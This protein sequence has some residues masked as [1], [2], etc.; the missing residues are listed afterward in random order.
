VKPNVDYGKAFALFIESGADSLREYMNSLNGDATEKLTMRD[1][2]AWPDD[3]LHSYLSKKSSSSD[4]SDIA[5]LRGNQFQGRL[6]YNQD[7]SFR[8]TDQIRELVETELDSKFPALD[9]IRAKKRA[10]LIDKLMTLSAPKESGK[11]SAIMGSKSQVI[12]A[13]SKDADLEKIVGLFIE[14]R[15]RR[16]LTPK[17]LFEDYYNTIHEDK[18]PNYRKW[19]TYAQRNYRLTF[20]SA[21]LKEA[22][23]LLRNEIPPEFKRPTQPLLE[24]LIQLHDTKSSKQG[25]YQIS[26]LSA[27]DIIGR[28]DM[29]KA[30]KRNDIYKYWKGKHSEFAEFT[31]AHNA[32]VAAIVD[33]DLS[34]HEELKRKIDEFSE[35][36]VDELNYIKLYNPV[37]IKDIDKIE[38]KALILLEEFLKNQSELPEE[39]IMYT[40]KVPGVK[41]SSDVTDYT[42]S[43]ADTEPVKDDLEE[44]ILDTLTDITVRKVDPLYAYILEETDAL[45]AGAVIEDQLDDI[46]D[47]LKTGLIIVEV[48]DLLPALEKFLAHLK[49]SKAGKL[50]EYYLPAMT[51]MM[52]RKDPN[53]AIAEYLK[54]FAQ[55][56]EYGEKNELQS[57]GGTTGLKPKGGRKRTVIGRSGVNA[58]THMNDFKDLGITEKF[59]LLLESI[60]KFF[61]E[62]SRNQNRPFDDELPFIEQTGSR[63]IERIA[64]QP[65]TG[66]SPFIHLLRMEGADWKLNKEQL[67]QIADFMKTITGI[68][69]GSAQ[70]ELLN[71]TENLG[72]LLNDIFAG[73]LEEMIEIELGNFLHGVFRDANLPDMKFGLGTKQ[74]VAELSGKYK[75]N[76]IYP[77]EALFNHI[78][79]KKESYTDKDSGVDG[80]EE[81]IRQIQTAERELDIIKSQE[82]KLILQAH[83]EI[84]KMLGK[85][86]YYGMA[87][88]DN[89]DAVNSAISYMSETYNTDITAMDVENVV[90]ELDSMNNISVKY[91]VPEEGVYFLKANFR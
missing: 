8:D 25:R 62:P 59:Q 42:A 57:K 58:K 89:Y 40:Q 41:D 49:K 23:D 1:M 91:G 78:Y 83:D 10:V 72:D 22:I 12:E 70:N 26:T 90:N 56:I 15:D 81:Y 67:K 71:K 88:I 30:E 75:K 31:K 4:E 39:K 48:G 29:K 37:E 7:G 73:E 50:K 17:K 66:E 24:E 79:L 69:V 84:R 43:E 9:N 11:A 34:Q 38:D 2:K 3:I 80:A 27:S 14:N 86:I 68:N 6:I 19:A 35:I 21:D 18:T 51:K 61:I 63:P 65:Q 60:V 20:T 36:E 52:P 45:P 85:P 47:L 54:M 55:F 44:E 53:P 87:S 13:A 76:E 32:F 46:E 28:L 5:I 74:S 64:Q 82:Q 16:K 33:L 77:F